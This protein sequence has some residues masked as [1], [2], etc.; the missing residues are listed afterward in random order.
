MYRRSAK[1]CDQHY[2]SIENL[3][4][5]C[6]RLA[7]LSGKLDPAPALLLGVC[8]GTGEHARILWEK[9][10][11][12]VDG[13][14]LEPN[15]VAIALE[16]DPD[17]FFSVADMRR[18]SLPSRYD[19]ITCLFSSIG[20]T[21]TERTLGEAIESMA[22]HLIPKG[23]LILEPW[24]EPDEWDADLVKSSRREDSGAGIRIEQRRTAR[25]EGSEPVNEIEYKIESP[26]EHFSFRETHRVGLFSREQIETTL[27]KRGFQSR[28]IPKGMLHHQVHAAQLAG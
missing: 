26:S 20:Y 13:I 2:R 17:N 11:Y 23:W 27:E 19:A 12:S 9:H 15:L 24:V 8:C 3:D 18:F 21:E 4:E 25:T 28:Y 1:W 22:K 7:Y 5:E 6:E 14:D 10:G 16:R